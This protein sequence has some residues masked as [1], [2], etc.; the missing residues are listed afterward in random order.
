M[1]T[2]VGA[3]ACEHGV[4]TTA[5]I[6]VGVPAI[7]IARIGLVAHIGEGSPALVRPDPADGRPVQGTWPGASSQSSTSGRSKERTSG[8]SRHTTAGYHCSGAAWQG[9]MAPVRRAI[10]RCM[11]DTRVYPATPQKSTDTPVLLPVVVRR[12]EGSGG[13]FDV[14][15]RLPAIL[16]WL[17]Q[18]LC[19]R[20]AAAAAETAGM[21]GA[22]GGIMGGDGRSGHSL[23]RR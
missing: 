17:H 15:P 6:E 23:Q 12:P 16:G 5:D 19:Q 13:R 2:V 18:P 20:Q 4:A 14:N 22:A 3:E 10:G 7:E 8:Q 21:T 9:P 11:L 1:C